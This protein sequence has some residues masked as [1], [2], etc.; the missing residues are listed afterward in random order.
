M[1][2]LLALLIFCP[3]AEAQT[4]APPAGPPGFAGTIK[5]FFDC[6]H[7][8]DFDFLREE[9]DYVDY[10]RDR[11][12]AEV[13][14]L[15]TTQRTG[16]G[17]EEFTLKYI[18][19]GRF[20]GRDHTAR[21]VTSGT[22]TDDEERRG[23][24]RVF[25]LGLA[26]YLADSPVGAEL[27]VRRTRPST[28]P[29]SA[30]AAKDK[31]NL[32]VFNVGSDLNFDGEHSETSRELGANFSANRTT[33]EWKLT[34]AADGEAN[35]NVFTLSDGRKVT[36]RSHNYEANAIAVKSVGPAHWAALGRL[37]TG[38][39]T[40]N[41]YDQNTRLMAGIEFSVFP[42][43]EST[44]RTLVVQYAAGLTHYRYIEPTIYGKTR[45]T[46]PEQLIHAVLALRQPWGSSTVSAAYV[47]LLDDFTKRRFELDGNLEF[48]VFRG[49]NVEIGAEASRVHDQIYL[50]AGEASDEEVL[51]RQRRLA[52]SYRYE[53][54]VGFSYRF[55][56]IFNNVVNPR[57]SR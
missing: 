25:A 39:S 8:C 32:W 47:T 3:P 43:S 11:S 38:A 22:D 30:T 10:V 40:Q 57:W 37:S 41:N 7:A 1:P 18:G 45:E 44:R 16:T 36:S 6:N 29:T 4:P 48:R 34:V 23:F 35:T 14:V 56:S 13:H 5:V 26:S 54:R 51:L 33:N 12:D 17:G 46:R 31:W 20:L 27:S 2:L 21:F 53:I 49:L 9:V 52:T 24:T 15:V 50:E 19:L 42:Y 28:P 55:G